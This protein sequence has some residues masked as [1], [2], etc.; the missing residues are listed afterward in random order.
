MYIFYFS[1]RDLIL[2]VGVYDTTYGQPLASVSTRFPEYN[3]TGTVGDIVDTIE[4]LVWNAMW[5]AQNIAGLYNLGCLAV[6]AL[7]VVVNT[8]L[9]IWQCP[10]CC[11]GGDYLAFTWHLERTWCFR[12]SAAIMLCY[13]FVALFLSFGVSFQFLTLPGLLDELVD[14]FKLIQIAW[15]DILLIVVSVVSIMVPREPIFGW[16]QESFKDLNFKRSWYSFFMETNDMFASEIASALIQAQMENKIPLESLL[17]DPAH[18]EIVMGTL[19]IA[20]PAAD[21]VFDTAVDA[22]G[23]MSAGGRAAPLVMSG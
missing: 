14:P 1:A 6:V 5:Q 4:E 8:I 19:L 9:L 10:S 3:E 16:K 22:F 15:Q 2:K 17:E 20:P 21:D 23:S 18:V 11:G 7:F 12:A 13:V